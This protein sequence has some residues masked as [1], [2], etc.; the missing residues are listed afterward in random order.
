MTGELNPMFGTSLYI[1]NNHTGKLPNISILNK[2]HRFKIGFQP[3]DWI[4]I[5]EWRDKNKNKKNSAY[6]KHWYN[7]GNNN[8]YLYPNDIRVETL[9][10][11]RLLKKKIDF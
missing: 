2:H 10:K 3:I 7:D 11:G 1:A 5:S 9:V 6:G 8:F 4:T